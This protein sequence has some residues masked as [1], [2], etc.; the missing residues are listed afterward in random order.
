M[1]LQL[2]T[3]CKNCPFAN[4]ETRIKFT[5][6]ERAEEIAESA[7][8]HGFPCHLS[9]ELREDDLDT[10][11]YVFS[12]DGSTQHCAGAIGMFL[13]SDYDEWPGVENRYMGDGK[14]LKAQAV[15]FESEEAFIEA[16]RGRRDE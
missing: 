9:A 3:P 13:N 16:N 6:R 1:R 7:Y 14:W 12:G 4:R 5:C 10:D 2:K 11:G 8:R 15:A